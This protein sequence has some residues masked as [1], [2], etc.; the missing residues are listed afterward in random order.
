MNEIIYE[1]SDLTFLSIIEEVLKDNNIPYTV[2]GG[3]DIG[4]IGPARIIK[5]SVP[6]EQVE[7]AK[8]VIK[9]L[10]TS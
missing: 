4:L 10:C 3:G 8:R 9:L 2:T 5:I 7:E 6:K 1:S